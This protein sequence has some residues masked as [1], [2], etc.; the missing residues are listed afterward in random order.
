M[1]VLTKKS[2]S[3]IFSFLSVVKNFF[4]TFHLDWDGWTDIKNCSCKITWTTPNFYDC[5]LFCT[6]EPIRSAQP[7]ALCCPVIISTA[8]WVIPVDWF[9]VSSI[10]WKNQ[11][12]IIDYFSCTKLYF[13]INF[14]HWFRTLTVFSSVMCTP[15]HV[16]NP[17]MSNKLIFSAAR[18]K[19]WV[20]RNK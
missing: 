15:P 18:I 11:K 4:A 14:E 3:R 2:F 8:F 19:I 17:L 9:S 12:S 1:T 7:I 6:H 10:T 16:Y 5:T 20:L 13:L